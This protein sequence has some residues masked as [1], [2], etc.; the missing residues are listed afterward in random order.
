[1]CA[2]ELRRSAT[3]ADVVG[4]R[5][6]RHS[7]DF[8]AC[9]RIVV[10]VR[11]NWTRGAKTDASGS[12][13]NPDNVGKGLPT[14]VRASRTPVVVRQTVL[15]VGPMATLTGKRTK[16]HEALDLDP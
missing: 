6:R 7:H 3:F 12:P 8:A 13:K 15:V 2:N 4:M 1:M 14:Y 16:R 9:G 5:S 10:D 11:E